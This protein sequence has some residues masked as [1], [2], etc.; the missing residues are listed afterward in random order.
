MLLLLCL[1]A[2]LSHT[3]DRM[4][5][6]PG[7]LQ[8][9]EV[10]VHQLLPPGPCLCCG[11]QALR[12]RDHQPKLWAEH[13]RTGVIDDAKAHKPV[14]VQLTAHK[15]SRSRQSTCVPVPGA[16]TPHPAQ[17]QAVLLLW[18]CLLCCRTHCQCQ[19]PGAHESL[20]SCC[21]CWCCCWPFK[22]NCWVNC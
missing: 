11:C 4:A 8:P 9:Q 17:H 22:T 3:P 15:V 1:A 13:R 2:C 6:S 18:V 12:H 21:W 5:A 20:L 14:E 19:L 10:L 16:P 7:L